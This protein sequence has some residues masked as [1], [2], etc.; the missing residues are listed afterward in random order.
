MFNLQTCCD[1]FLRSILSINERGG[2][3]CFRLGVNFVNLLEFLDKCIENFAIFYSDME[4]P[5]IS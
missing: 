1:D 4:R 2:W 3:H 5:N